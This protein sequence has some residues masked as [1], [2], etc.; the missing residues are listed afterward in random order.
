MGM[1]DNLITPLFLST[2]IQILF[3]LG[4]SLALSGVL[5]RNSNRIIDYH[6]ALPLPKKWLFAEYAVSYIVES[7]LISAPLLGLGLFALHPLFSW[8]AISW[9]LFIGAYLLALIFFACFFLWISFAYSFTW[10]MDNIWARRLA[11]LYLFGCLFFPWKKAWSFSPFW[12]TAM[13]AN[14]FTYCIEGLRSALIGTEQFISSWICI[15]MLTVF[16]V[17]FIRLLSYSITK[18]L[19]PV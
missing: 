17:I 4:Y 9:P 10:F 6:L 7:L 12:A 19:D 5:D 16:N 8:S 3:S 13:L 14:P 2:A 18:E 15:A 11:P 1:P